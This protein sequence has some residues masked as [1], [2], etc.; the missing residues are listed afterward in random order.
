MPTAE[1][2]AAVAELTDILKRAKGLYLT[3]FTGLDV[4]SFTLLR[5]QLREESVSCR[6]I[7]NRLAKLAIKRAGVEGLDDVL[8]GPTGLVCA[9]EDPVAPARMLSKFAKET[10]GKPVIKAGYI[11]GEV[12]VADQVE[13]LA[14]IPSR[15]VLLGQMVSAMQ[16]PISG[17]AFTLNGILQKLVGT[18][19]AVAEKKKG[20]RRRIDRLSHTQ[21]I[22]GRRHVHGCRI[23][24]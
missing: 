9:D 8:R 6:V 23:H 17:L 11:D 2:E 15:D 4:P 14:Q 1:K 16:S 19:H 7:K 24:Y 10:D 5:K 21:F 18:L 13:R 12:F 22:V 20:S 3:D